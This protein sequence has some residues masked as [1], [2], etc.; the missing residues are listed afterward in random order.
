MAVIKVKIFVSEIANVLSLFDVIEIQ[1][2]EAGSPYTDAKNIT[3][4]VATSAV[5]VG[6]EEGPFSGLQGTTL[7]IKVD[8]GSEQTH[9]FTTAD[10]ISLA[11]VIGELNGSITGITAADD[12]TGKL[13]ITSDEV[14]TDSVLEITGGSSLATLGFTTGD[15]DNGEDQHVALQ[16]GVS[17]YEYDDQSG[18]A[19]YWYRSR[20]L[21]TVSGNVSTWA[22]WIQGST[23]AALDSASLIIGKVKLADVDGTALVGAK[24]Q[25]VNVYNPLIEDTYFIAGRSKTIETDGTGSAEVTLIKGSTID[26]IIE[27]T[28]II[29]RIVVPDT[30]TEFDL[31]DESL[32]TD[33]PFGIQTPDLPAAVR[34]T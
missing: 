22:D 20:F 18:A 12:G 33:D 29:R 24:V 25:V 3:D 7:Q 17:D 4:D 34:R 21:N 16:V 23:G 19:S 32:V 11:N 6:T 2:S 9:T 5:L 13:Q 8:Q 14:G 28:S 27:G 15:K 31:L 26:V 1:R 30:G 10:P